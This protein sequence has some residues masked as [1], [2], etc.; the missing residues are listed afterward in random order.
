MEQRQVNRIP[1]HITVYFVNPLQLHNGALTIFQATFTFCKIILLPDTNAA[2]PANNP[3]ADMVI[4]SFKALWSTKGRV[5]VE[6]VKQGKTMIG[7][8]CKGCH[9]ISKRRLWQS[10]CAENHRSGKLDE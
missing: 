2:M 10:L 8:C 9:F 1:E 7:L 5:F 4:D 3:R 6:L